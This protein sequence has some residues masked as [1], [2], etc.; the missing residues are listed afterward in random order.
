MKAASFKDVYTYIIFIL[1]KQILIL[2]LGRR[3]FFNQV[4]LVNYPELRITGKFHDDN[5]ITSVLNSVSF[6]LLYLI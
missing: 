6:I 1:Y 3:T 2:V 5:T 4:G